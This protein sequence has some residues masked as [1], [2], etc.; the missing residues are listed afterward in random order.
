[1]FSCSAVAVLRS[2]YYCCLTHMFHF[3][4][5]T[6]CARR[7]RLLSVALCGCP[8]LECHKMLCAN[9]VL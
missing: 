9:V 4:Q 6:F 3:Y 7:S 8:L 1:M 2:P 5:E